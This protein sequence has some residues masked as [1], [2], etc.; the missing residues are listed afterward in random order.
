LKPALDQWLFRAELEES[1]W[2]NCSP[3][4]YTNVC[5]SFAEISTFRADKKSLTIILIGGAAF[6]LFMA[7]ALGVSYAAGTRQV[8][9][10][11]Y[12][13]ASIAQVQPD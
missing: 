1:V 11:S 8:S 9:T 10:F 5:I 4:V 3:I 2:C 7:V 6:A 12:L 13:L